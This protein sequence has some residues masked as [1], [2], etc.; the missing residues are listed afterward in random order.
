[1]AVVDKDLTPEQQLAQTKEYVEQLP[2]T[3]V[4]KIDAFPL[5]WR[6]TRRSQ[7]ADVAQYY[8]DKREYTLTVDYTTTAA[9]AV[10]ADFF[11]KVKAP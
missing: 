3:E 9:P 7:K 11:A 6:E 2:N 8:I 4:V 10:A 1:V 5:R